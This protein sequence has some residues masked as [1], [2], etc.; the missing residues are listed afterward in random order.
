M[1]GD[2]NGDFAVNDAD[3]NILIANYGLS[4]P[5]YAQGDLNGDHQVDLADIDLALAQY[6]LELAIVS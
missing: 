4:N 6:G 1:L 2:L 3:L 5:T